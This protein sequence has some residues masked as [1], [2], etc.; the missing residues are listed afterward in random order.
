V[1]NEVLPSSEEPVTNS[2]HD[3]TA[4]GELSHICEGDTDVLTDLLPKDLEEG[5]LDTLHKEIKWQRMSHQGGDV[6]RLVAVQGHI[7]DDGSVPIYRHPSDESP[8]LLPFSPT[9]L[10]IKTAT[11]A[12]LGHPLN[13]ALIQFYRDG[14]DFISEHSDKTL[15][16]VHGSFI[17]NVS[18]GAERTMIL[19]TKRRDKDPSPDSS[20]AVPDKSDK[21]KIHRV[22]LPHNSLLRMGLKTNMKWLHSIR[23]DKRA[24]RDKSVAELAFN[25]ARISLTFRQIGTFLSKDEKSI[26]GQGAQAKTRETAR[27]VVNGQG[28]EA[29]GML[30]AFGAENHATSFDWDAYYGRGFDV[31]H[32]SASPRFFA[33]QDPVVNMRV[34]LMLAELG[35]TYAKGSMGPLPSRAPRGGDFLPIKFVDNDEG[36]STVEG[37]VAILIYLDATYGGTKNASQNKDKA[38]LAS[39]YTRFQQALSLSSRFRQELLDGDGKTN[40]SFAE[41][42]LPLWNR[43]A[44]E[45]EGEFLVGSI[46][47]LPDFVVWPILHALIQEHGLQIMDGQKDLKRYY[48]DFAA[49]ECVRLALGNPVEPSS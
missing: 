13:H 45:M 40:R 17:A 20:P 19:R 26:W 9:V 12:R 10:A 27:P 3:E 31:L 22:R 2:S 16:I 11:E 25:G 42:E 30:K 15:D 28:P 8:R 43:H 21:R 6:P 39:R 1:P 23:Q 36:K 29:V 44:V 18:L 4:G 5:I 14:S 24:D 47:S 33:S 37:D 32:M 49:R 34:A 7:G 48:D 38:V 41:R 35:V 46:P